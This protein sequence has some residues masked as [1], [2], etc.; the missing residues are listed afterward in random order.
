V[1]SSAAAGSFPANILLNKSPNPHK[2]LRKSSPSLL[3]SFQNQARS[4][5]INQSYQAA[6]DGWRR[7]LDSAIEEARRI[8]EQCINTPSAR[9]QGMLH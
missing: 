6:G 2:L 5:S 9:E 4:Q 1:K 3:L 8:T 7:P